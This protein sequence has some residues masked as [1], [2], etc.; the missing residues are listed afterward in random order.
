MIRKLGILNRTNLALCV[1]FAI[2]ACN[3]G[4]ITE[5]IPHRERL[6]DVTE[7]D[8]QKLSNKKIYFGHQSVG[9]NIMDGIEDLQKENLRI[10]LNIVETNEL[11]KI[12]Q[13]IFA[14]SRIGRNGDPKSKI[15]D[16]ATFI[17]QAGEDRLDY[18]GMKFCYVDMNA[19]TDVKK[20]FS[21]YSTAMAKLKE[22]HPKMTIIHFTMPLMVN[23][24]SWKT[25]IKKI[26]GKTEIWEYAA[27]TNRNRFNQLIIEA[28]QGKEPLLDIAKIESTK[29]DGSRQAFDQNGVTYYSMAPE[30]SYDNGHLNEIG[31]KRVAEQLLLLLINL[32]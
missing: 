22:L 1:A 28:Y 14:H 10:K 13:G 12:S 27:N 2:A 26:F 11:E 19:D 8:W 5:Q 31:R 4:S 29:P 24:E 30:Y 16:F 9:F 3:G 17:N 15:D 21:D 32:K 20:L 25:K 23:R 6:G 7:A 18:A